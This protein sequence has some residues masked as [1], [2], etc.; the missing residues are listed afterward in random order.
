[1]FAGTQT[2]GK[3]KG[4]MAIFVVQKYMEHYWYLWKM[5]F[6]HFLKSTYVSKALIASSVG[7]F[8]IAVN[9]LCF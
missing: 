8:S 7:H 3:N 9:G 6:N 2:D 5:L 1:M 4:Q